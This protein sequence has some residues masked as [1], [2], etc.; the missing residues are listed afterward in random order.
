MEVIVVGAGVTGL[1]VTLH[2]LEGGATVRL[3]DR[4]GIGAGASGVQPGGVRRQWATEANCRL[5]QESY[6]YYLEL[7][8]RLGT[9]VRPRF[10]ACGYAFVA[11]TEARLAELDAAVALQ[12]R[13]GVPSRLLA[14]AE[15]AEVVPELEPGG[16]V[17][18]AWCAEDGYF[19]R[20]QMPVEAFAEAVLARG[21]EV[22]R[23][24]VETLDGL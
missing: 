23:E 12:Q 17:G 2:L 1:A 6:G 19:D 15:A 3:V 24:D 11:H 9:R 13:L 8:D 18:A 16:I 10:T 22:V 14:P 4:A 5:A 7:A 21:A 20:A